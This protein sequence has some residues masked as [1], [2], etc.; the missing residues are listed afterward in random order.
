MNKTLPLAL[1]ALLAA[2]FAFASPAPYKG[3]CESPEEW[4]HHSYLAGNGALLLSYDGNVTG[5]CDGDTVPGDFD[6]HLEGGVG[7]ALLTAGPEDPAFPGCAVESPHH[8][9]VIHVAANFLPSGVGF[10]VGADNDCDGVTDVAVA[11][12]DSCT[13]AFPPGADGAYAVFVDLCCGK[14]QVY[15]A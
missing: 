1:A 10:D 9:S 13:P 15:T 14:G 5:D 8:S 2:P 3:Y 6:G 12:I 7:G 4:G 11:C